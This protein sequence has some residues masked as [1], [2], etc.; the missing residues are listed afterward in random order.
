MR[1]AVFVGP[2]PKFPLLISLLLLC[3]EEVNRQV[4]G[5]TRPR[6]CQTVSFFFF[7]SLGGVRIGWRMT[8]Y[9]VPTTT[10]S[11]VPLAK[12]ANQ[13][14]ES[15]V[16][17]AWLPAGSMHTSLT[18]WTPPHINGGLLPFYDFL[19]YLSLFCYA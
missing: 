4:N 2:D 16:Y 7:E 19:H 6:G 5:P 13:L 18:R 9:V 12:N 14:L 10:T 17:K 3:C 1:I 11:S 8:L 15:C